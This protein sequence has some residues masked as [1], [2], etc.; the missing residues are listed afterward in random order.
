MFN[1][2][3]T[4]KYVSSTLTTDVTST[5]KSTL[6]Y[7]SVSLKRVSGAQRKKGALP[8]SHSVS[9][10]CLVLYHAVL[11]HAA[12]SCAALPP[13]S[14]HRRM[15]L[16]ETL[17]VEE[18]NEGHAAQLRRARAAYQSACHRP[19]NFGIWLGSDPGGQ[20]RL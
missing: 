20:Q 10:S 18:R 9:G 3:G 2:Q 19:C 14:C 7:G 12:F 13:P 6:L 8:P 5:H 11:Y 16:E 15:G 4:Q 1:I 17:E